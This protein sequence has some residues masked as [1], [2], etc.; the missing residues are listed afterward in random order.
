M[1]LEHLLYML[2]ADTFKL[3]LS[4]KVVVINC[5]SG[6]HEE[7]CDRSS[8]VWIQWP[9]SFMFITLNPQLKQLSHLY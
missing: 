4:S 1:N 2:W 3:H 8:T 6:S 7:G 5:K 9:A